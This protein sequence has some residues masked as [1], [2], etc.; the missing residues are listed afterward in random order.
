MHG[1]RFYRDSNPNL[2]AL[3]NIYSF[4]LKDCN[5]EA[6]LAVDLGADFTILPFL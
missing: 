1:I 5:F 2:S 3:G 4:Q 6:L